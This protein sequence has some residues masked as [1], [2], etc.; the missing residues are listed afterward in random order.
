MRLYD[1]NRAV[2]A[3]WEPCPLRLRRVQRLVG[4]GL[5]VPYLDRLAYDL[6]DGERVI[7]TVT[8]KDLGL[9][10]PERLRDM[11]VISAILRVEAILAAEAVVEGSGA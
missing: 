10:V 5:A 1:L 2:R 8:I 3:A 4:H 9:R 6:L 7:G 11:T